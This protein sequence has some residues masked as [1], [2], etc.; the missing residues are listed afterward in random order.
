M[1]AYSNNNTYNK[2]EKKSAKIKQNTHKTA[3][4]HSCFTR[5]NTRHCKIDSNT[6]QRRGNGNNNNNDV[7]DGDELVVHI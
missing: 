2:P 7:D 6:Q 3:E 1:Y 5:L 4:K